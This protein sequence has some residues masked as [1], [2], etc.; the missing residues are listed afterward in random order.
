M[1]ASKFYVDKFKN[2]TNWTI[3]QEALLILYVDYFKNGTTWT[4]G[5]E[6]S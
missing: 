5:Q 3:G 6:V 1:L 2:R 4:Y